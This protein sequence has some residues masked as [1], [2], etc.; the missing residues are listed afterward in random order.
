MPPKPTTYQKRFRLLR[1]EAGRGSMRAM[2]ELH[3]RYHVNRLMMNGELVS[4]E[5][6]LKE[7]L[8]RR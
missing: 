8:R 1:A 4:L 7:S 2:Q 6:R 5:D 3:Q